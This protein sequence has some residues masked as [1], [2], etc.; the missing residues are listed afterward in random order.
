MEG[1]Y[2]RIKGVMYPCYVVIINEVCQEERDDLLRAF[3]HHPVEDPKSWSSTS[4]WMKGKNML[5]TRIEQRAA[6]KRAAKKPKTVA[7]PTTRRSRK[8]A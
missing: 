6:A 3:S 2:A 4:D 7:P 1:G 8:A 5:L